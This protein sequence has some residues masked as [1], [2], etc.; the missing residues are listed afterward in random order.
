MLLFLTAELI[1]GTTSDMLSVRGIFIYTNIYIKDD[2]RKRSV[3][4]NLREGISKA[5]C[6]AD[7]SNVRPRY[8]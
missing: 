7:P 8:P 5:L 4:C 3:G 6:V 1:K 2:N